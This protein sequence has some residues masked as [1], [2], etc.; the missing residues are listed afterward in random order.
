[1]GSASVVAA[2]NP[3]RKYLLTHGCAIQ[4]KK[5]HPAKPGCPNRSLH[6]RV[7]NIETVFHFRQ[8][9]QAL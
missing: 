5:D 9:S 7:D 1:M 2:A 3:A 8:D 6:S 4:T